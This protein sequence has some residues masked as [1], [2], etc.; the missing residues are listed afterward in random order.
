MG[1]NNDW[2]LD[3]LSGTYSIGNIDDA[4]DSLI[5]QYES[6]FDKIDKDKRNYILEAVN[7]MKDKILTS[8]V[9]GVIEL[10][11]PDDFSSGS[12]F[13]IIGT[14]LSIIASKYTA[15]SNVTGETLSTLVSKMNDDFEKREDILDA[16]VQRGYL[17][18]SNLLTVSDL[19]SNRDA[20]SKTSGDISVAFASLHSYDPSNQM[21]VINKVDF[22]TRYIPFMA[23]GEAGNVRMNFAQAI[24][25]IRLK[26]SNISYVDMDI[27]DGELKGSGSKISEYSETQPAAQGSDYIDLIYVILNYANDYTVNIGGTDYIYTANDFDSAEDIASGLE[28][29]LSNNA[30]INVLTETGYH[31]I[32]YE[33]GNGEKVF[34]WYVEDTD[35]SL[36]YSV[37]MVVPSDTHD[38]TIEQDGADT[39]KIIITFEHDGF[40][41]VYPT[42]GDIVDL[43]NNFEDVPIRVV[44]MPG[45]NV[46]DEYNTADDFSLEIGAS[47]V[48]IEAQ[49]QLSVTVATTG[50][51]EKM[52]LEHV[53]DYSVASNQIGTIEVVKFNQANTYFIGIDGTNVDIDPSDGLHDDVVDEITLAASFATEINNAGLGVTASSTGTIITLTVDNGGESKTITTSG[54][55]NY[56]VPIDRSTTLKYDLR[57]IPNV[58]SDTIIPLI[59]KGEIVTSDMEPLN[60]A[61]VEK[62][63]TS[64][65][66][67]TPN[68]MLLPRVPDVVD[69]SNN[70]VPNIQR[71]SGTFETL[72]RK[73]SSKIENAGDNLYP[74]LRSFPVLKK[75]LYAT[76]QAKSNRWFFVEAG[77]NG[78]AAFSSLNVAVSTIAPKDY[79]TMILKDSAASFHNAR[80]R[81]PGHSEVYESILSLLEERTNSYNKGGLSV[82][83]PI[84]ATL[85]SSDGMSIILNDMTDEDIDGFIRYGLIKPIVRSSN[86]IDGKITSEDP[87]RL[88]IELMEL[89]IQIDDSLIEQRFIAL[90]GAYAIDASKLTGLFADP[91]F[92]SYVF[93]ADENETPPEDNYGIGGVPIDATV[94][95][96]KLYFRNMRNQAKPL[97]IKSYPLNIPATEEV[98]LLST[99]PR[100]GASTTAATASFVMQ[101]GQELQTINESTISSIELIPVFG[102]SDVILDTSPE[103][104][105]YSEIA[106]AGYFIADADLMLNHSLSG[107]SRKHSDSLWSIL[108]DAIEISDD[109]EIVSINSAK[110]YIQTLYQ[111][112]SLTKDEF[113][114]LMS[115]FG[116]QMTIGGSRK[117]YSAITTLHIKILLYLI[118]AGVN[119]ADHETTFGELVGKIFMDDEFETEI[120]R[121]ENFRAWMVSIGAHYAFTD[122]STI[123]SD[124]QTY[125]SGLSGFTAE[126]IASSFG[127]QNP[128]AGDTVFEMTYGDSSEGSYG[129]NVPTINLKDV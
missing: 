67:M 31:S 51:P 100:I 42:I 5:D 47:M 105:A 90:S 33:N 75:R 26:T 92:A 71:P 121:Y 57:N 59:K 66:V 32:V 110:S 34:G 17:S 13:R 41:P 63:V 83:V 117:Q 40:D 115:E 122:A 14:G 9:D 60:R 38:L 8:K 96:S 114:I 50:E 39:E 81:I 74:I 127:V 69:D 72:V 103:D 23:T 116:T 48:R 30:G 2:L 77:A 61:D 82:E 46:D 86:S 36:T 7:T 62:L 106:R 97:P 10:V 124:N 16:A 112:F 87:D 1:I 3:N 120:L 80:G 129:W 88:F 111:S 29:E 44:V 58:D 53:S 35:D 93:G 49:S 6:L 107:I 85:Y 79:E 54:E 52:K 95:M 70:F 15:G 25:S 11:D 73:E 21:S 27:T 101:S 119:Y 108:M 64:G 18:A 55:F 28:S 84:P 102:S 113:T 89:A 109:G 123:D 37:S 20:I 65:V 4:V 43:V 68:Y 56:V 76:D 22:M 78:V 94:T 12:D 128:S 24:N 45:F 118:S 98:S 99:L 19:I 125:I 91:L 104:M 126:F